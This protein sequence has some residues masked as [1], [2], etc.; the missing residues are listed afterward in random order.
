MRIED[1]QT[2][3]AMRGPHTGHAHQ[4]LP[5][6]SFLTAT[7]ICVQLLYAGCK[8]LNVFGESDQ[9]KADGAADSAGQNDSTIAV[10]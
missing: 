4:S 8:Q 3:A 10:D 5:L 1:I 6:G 2:V 7:K 9:G